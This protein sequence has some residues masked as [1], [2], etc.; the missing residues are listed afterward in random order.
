MKSGT[1]MHYGP[2]GV[3]TTTNNLCD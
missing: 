1:G 3:R 2:S